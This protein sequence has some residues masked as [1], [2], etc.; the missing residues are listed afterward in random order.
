M[1]LCNICLSCFF[2]SLGKP[3]FNAFYM[4]ISRAWMTSC[5]EPHPNSA[6]LV[7]SAMQSSSAAILSWN[8]ESPKRAGIDPSE[9]SSM[10]SISEAYFTSMSPLLHRQA[11][12]SICLPSHTIE[13]STGR[14][15]TRQG[16]VSFETFPTIWREKQA[17]SMPYVKVHVRCHLSCAVYGLIT[18]YSGV[19]QLWFY[20]H[21]SRSG[22]FCQSFL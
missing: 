17:A 21:Y 7:S 13:C 15:S 14:P 11:A 9:Y 1:C 3:C 2:P 8:I 4:H 12:S 16:I 5:S 19:Y 10:P 22:S 18:C 6:H 20:W